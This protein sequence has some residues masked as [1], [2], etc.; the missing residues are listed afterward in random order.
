[1]YVFTLK[2]FR[3]LLIVYFTSRQSINFYH[4]DKKNLSDTFIEGPSTVFCVA[5]VA[6]TVVIKPSSIPKLSLMILAK[7]AKQFVVQDALL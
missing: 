4:T 5:V 3:Q 6:C 1:M 7:G 2:M